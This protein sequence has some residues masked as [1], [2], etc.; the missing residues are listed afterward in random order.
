MTK[1]ILYEVLY[2]SFGILNFPFIFHESPLDSFV[3][4]Y[5]INFLIY[6][7]CFHIKCSLTKKI[8]IGELL[9]KYFPV[10]KACVT[11]W[12]FLREIG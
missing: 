5:I 12:S 6:N 3:V 2:V 1:G 10:E 11:R 9:E 4:V 8:Y 7:K